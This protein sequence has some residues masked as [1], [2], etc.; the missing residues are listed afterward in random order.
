MVLSSGNGRRTV[1]SG[2]FGAVKRFIRPLQ[3]HFLR[4]FTSQLGNTKTDRDFDI[5]ALTRDFQC[6]YL[7]PKPFRKTVSRRQTGLGQQAAELFTSVPRQIIRF[8][9]YRRDVGGNRLQHGVATLMAVVVIDFFEKIDVKHD[10]TQLRTIAP[11]PLTFFAKPRLK[12]PPVVYAGQSVL[13]VHL[14]EFLFIGCKLGNILDNQKN[15]VNGIKIVPQWPQRAVLLHVLE[16]GLKSAIRPE[17]KEKMVQ[18]LREERKIAESEYHFAASEKA[19]GLEFREKI[20]QKS[21]G[22]TL[23]IYAAVPRHPLIPVF[24]SKLAVE[25]DETKIDNFKY[26]RNLIH[27]VS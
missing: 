20:Q 12:E 8:P 7:M 9:D 5:M 1:S 24:D 17:R 4:I 21:A 27:T 11:M 3:K 15:A 13:H 19:R 26:L 18:L 22:D 6:F 14:D 2:A 10:Q 16:H 23:G 25:N